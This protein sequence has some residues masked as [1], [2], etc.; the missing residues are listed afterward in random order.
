MIHRHK[1][2]HKFNVDGS[3]QHGWGTMNM[4]GELWRAFG[5]TLQEYDIGLGQGIKLMQESNFR[6]EQRSRIQ[7]RI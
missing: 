7:V 4:D 2:W 1:K 6:L 3:S 5:A